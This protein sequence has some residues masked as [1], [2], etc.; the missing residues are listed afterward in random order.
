MKLRLSVLGDLGKAVYTRDSFNARRYENPILNSYGHPVPLIDGHLQ[1]PGKDSA[2]RV[3]VFRHD[4]ETAEVVLDLKKAYPQVPGLQLLERSFRYRFA[5]GETIITDMAELI[6][7]AAFETAL[8]TFG[9]I[10]AQPD[11]SLL[12]KYRD[13]TVRILIDTGGV[14]W[15]LKK[16]ALSGNAQW[17]DPP[18]RYAIVPEGKRSS[19]KIEMTFQPV[20]QTR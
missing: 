5:D 2:A 11:G 16:E 14:P 10:E 6:R 7:P 9:T 20:K 13:S 1:S 3:K 15:S 12:A 4:T 17:P 8:T 19:W 18:Y